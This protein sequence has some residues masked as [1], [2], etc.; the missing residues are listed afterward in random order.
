MTTAETAARTATLHFRILADGWQPEPDEHIKNPR[1]Y[2]KLRR[3]AWAEIIKGGIVIEDIRIDEVTT[4][5]PG[6]IVSA[7]PPMTDRL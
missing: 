1:L 4:D 5:P 2:N 7:H 3:I 6:W